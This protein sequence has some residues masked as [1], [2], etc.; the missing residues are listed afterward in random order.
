MFAWIGSI[1]QAYGVCPSFAQAVAVVESRPAGTEIALRVGPIGG[2]RFYGP[3]AIHKDYL[4]RWPIDV[5]WINCVVGVRALRGK[6]KKRVLQ[7]YNRSWTPAYHAEVM[8]IKKQIER[9]GL[10]K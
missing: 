6:D 9:R 7:R 8:R 2:G 3:F 1:A 4:K 10:P 5:P